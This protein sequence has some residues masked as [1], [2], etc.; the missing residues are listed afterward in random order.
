MNATC[1]IDVRSKRVKERVAEVTETEQGETLKGWRDEDDMTQTN[2]NE[3]NGEDAI[4][5]ISTWGENDLFIGC[6]FRAF[7]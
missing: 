6:V 1:S 7:K 3:T 4:Q 2:D 5:T